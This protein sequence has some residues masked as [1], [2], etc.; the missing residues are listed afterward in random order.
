MAFECD[1]SYKSASTLFK[2]GVITHVK[3][4]V[5]LVLLLLISFLT[6][7]GNNETNGTSNDDGSTNHVDKNVE[8][9]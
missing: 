2:K 4:S 1:L 5:S 3:K 6:A 9:I 8:T 7:C